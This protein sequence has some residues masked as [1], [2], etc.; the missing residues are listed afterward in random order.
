MDTLLAVEGLFDQWLESAF[1]GKTRMGVLKTLRDNAGKDITHLLKNKGK[2]KKKEAPA[3]KPGQ[4]VMVSRGLKTASMESAEPKLPPMHPKMRPDKPGK[5]G[6]GPSM[7]SMMP[8]RPAPK[9]KL[10]KAGKAPEMSDQQKMSK[11]DKMLKR[12]GSTLRK[13]SALYQHLLHKKLAEGKP[14]TDTEKAALNKELGMAFGKAKPST[15]S[16]LPGQKKPQKLMSPFKKKLIG[17]GEKKEGLE[18]ECDDDGSGNP[19]I[20]WD[21]IVKGYKSKE[22]RGFGGMSREG[23]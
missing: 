14:L 15:I 11:L 10:K 19:S 16:G 9:A 5:S 8:N 2:E 22:E 7:R 1:A 23:F 21:R 18:F 17:R 12:S 4:G 6:E 3:A 13:E 20:P